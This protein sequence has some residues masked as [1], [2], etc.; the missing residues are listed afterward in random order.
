[1]TTSSST[2]PAATAPAP[3]GPPRWRPRLSLRGQDIGLIAVLALLCV[4]FSVQSP[5]FASQSNVTNILQSVSIIGTMAAVMTLVL[6]CGALD[7]SVGAVV[8]LSGVSAAI[9]MSSFGWPA[10]WAYAAAL[11]TGLL[12]GLFNGLA[13]TR[14]RINPIIVTIGT[15][16]LFRGI[17]FIV[18][19]GK[20]IAV[21]DGLSNWLG[22]ERLLFVPATVWVMALAFLAAWWVARFT[23]AGRTVYAVGANSRAARLAGLPIE[24]TR[25]LIMVASGLAAGVAGLLLCAQAGIA[26]PAAGTG[27]ELQVLTAVLLGGTSLVGGE[28]RVTGTL[29]GVLIIGVINNGMTLLS[30]PSY[31]QTV[32][33]GALL[34]IAV[35]I[36]QFR[37]GAVYR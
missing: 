17:A 6:V 18:T 5:H 28:G 20:D 4:F 33:S 22:F 8:G 29:L 31:Y 7:L 32:A 37:R 12:C 26:V 24:R 19:D 13:V 10:P 25:L 27:Y 15:L 3:G 21:N 1:M 14:L 30:V 34:L 11:V 36:D 9:L 35:A 2:Q 23:T 16:S